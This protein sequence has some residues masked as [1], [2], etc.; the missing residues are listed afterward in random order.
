MD[1]KN[2]ER[3]TDRVLRETYWEFIEKKINFDIIPWPNRKI[4]IYVHVKYTAW[5]L[6]TNVFIY[7]N[8]KD[9]IRKEMQKYGKKREN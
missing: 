8:E 4:N 7:L 3:L 9:I 2:K 6:F 5:W 1:F